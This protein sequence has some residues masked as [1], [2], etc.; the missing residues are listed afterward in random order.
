MYLLMGRRWFVFIKNQ[1]I[2]MVRFKEL[3]FGYFIKRSHVMD[4]SLILN[5]LAEVAELVDAPD[6]KSGGG[7]LV[8]VRVSP[9]APIYRFRKATC[10]TSGF[11]ALEAVWKFAS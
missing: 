1:S 7:N 3:S 11:F 8:R 10:Y 6:S 9:P 5:R 2:E 4:D